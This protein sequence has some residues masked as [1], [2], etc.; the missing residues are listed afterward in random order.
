MSFIRPEARAALWG[1]EAPEVASSP[2]KRTMAAHLSAG[3]ADEILELARPH[4]GLEPG[5]DR[6]DEISLSTNMMADRIY[7][8][9][10]PVKLN[11][12]QGIVRKGDRPLPTSGDGVDVV[13]ENPTIERYEVGSADSTVAFDVISRLLAGMP[14][15]RMTLDAS[16]QSLVVLARPSEHKTIV[17]ALQKLNGDAATLAVIPLRRMDPVA[18]LQTINK[19]F[20]KTADNDVGPKVDGD[21]V[22]KKLWVK[23]TAQEIEQVKQLIE[24]VQWP[25]EHPEVFLKYGQKP[26]RVRIHKLAQARRLRWLSGCAVLWSSGLWQDPDG[27]DHSPIPRRAI[28]HSGRHN[29]DGIRLRGRGRGE[30]CAETVCQLRR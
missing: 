29:T 11:L 10:D 1:D 18:A 3:L 13:I 15:V 24:M 6:S 5:V 23:G 4:L 16:T 7:A 22:T 8:T 26:S 17:E 30:R 25:F 9:G 27:Q 14:D 2:V 21:P 20:G 28:R 19:Y 12:L